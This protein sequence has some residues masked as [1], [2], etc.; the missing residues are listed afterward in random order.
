MNRIVRVATKE[1]HLL[2]VMLE[3]GHSIT[4]NMESRLQTMR[5]SLLADDWFFSQ[6]VT[7]GSYV[8]WGNA[9]EIS[10]RELFQLAQ[11]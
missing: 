3:N 2:E 11:Q 4:L 8:R 6:A 9:V 1:G 5:F 10:V 7:D